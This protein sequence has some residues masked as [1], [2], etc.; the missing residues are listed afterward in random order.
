MPLLTFKLCRQEG[1][2]LP[3]ALGGWYRGVGVQAGTVAPIT[4]LQMMVNGVLGGLLLRGDARPLTDV[5]T[6]SAACG[7]GVVAAWRA[8]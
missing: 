1:R 8:A 4:A 2:A 7:A 3:S 6:V 5:E